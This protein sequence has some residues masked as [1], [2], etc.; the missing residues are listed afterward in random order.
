MPVLR[1]PFHFVHLIITNLILF[2]S[3][4]WVQIAP[5]LEKNIYT[6]TEPKPNL[7]IIIICLKKSD[8]TVYFSTKTGLNNKYFV[9]GK[10]LTIEGNKTVEISV[11][12][13]RV[14]LLDSK[15]I[16]NYEKVSCKDETTTEYWQQRIVENYM[17]TRNMSCKPTVTMNI[18]N[19]SSLAVCTEEEEATIVQNINDLPDMQNYCTDKEKCLPVCSQEML[20]YCTESTRDNNER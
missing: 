15:G 11:A 4:K 3:C 13:E 18:F 12:K 8:S 6:F 19:H 10:K 9:P 17:E 1:S 7:D 20:L 16:M 5:F 14:T 2:W